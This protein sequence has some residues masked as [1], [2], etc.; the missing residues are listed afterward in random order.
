VL[1]RNSPLISS[2]NLPSSDFLCSM[3]W[4]LCFVTRL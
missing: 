4:E 1:P 2:Q 3:H